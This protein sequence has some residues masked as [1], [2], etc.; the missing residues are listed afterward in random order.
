MKENNLIEILRPPS[1]PNDNKINLSNLAMEL[2]D[3]YLKFIEVYGTGKI[4]NFITI[5]NCNSQDDDY[6]LFVQA[7]LILEDLR[8]LLE[9]DPTYYKS[10]LYPNQD[11]LYPI[12]V[13]DNGDY[14]FWV[15]QGNPNEWTIAI[16]ASR[17]PDVE[18][19]KYNLNDFLFNVL[20]K[21]TNIDSFP[22]SFPSNIIFEVIN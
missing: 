22:S 6:N 12:G 18:H 19:T 4:S 11:A 3:D 21:K 14:I 10:N 5:F 9:D 17:S 16:I 15:T 7:S 2:P 13:T 20:L 1:K 8:F